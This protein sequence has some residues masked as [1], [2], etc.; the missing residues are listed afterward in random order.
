MRFSA[1]GEIRYDDGGR[2]FSD[3]FTVGTY[4]IA[5]DLITVHGEGECAGEQFAM[6]AALPEA[7]VMNVVQNPSGQ[8]TCGF[9]ANERRVLEQVLPTNNEYLAGLEISER[10]VADLRPAPNSVWLH[11]DWMAQGGGHVL[12]SWHPTGATTSR[13]GPVTW[14]T[15]A[16]GLWT[17]TQPSCD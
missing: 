7:G 4:S 10:E 11:G 14:S 1:D 13:K 16:A 6:R 15:A 3:P 12:R 2:L 5:G 8:A 17:L 9:G